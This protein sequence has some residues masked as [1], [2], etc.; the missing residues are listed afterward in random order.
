MPVTIAAI[1]L[2]SR[3][4]TDR[5]YRLSTSRYREND[6]MFRDRAIPGS[7]PRYSNHPRQV[8]FPNDAEDI[9]A[10]PFFRGIPWSRLHLSQPPFAPH[11]RGDQPITKYFD[12][13]EEIMSQSD[14]LDTSTYEKAPA[15][16]D[17][18]G[19][20]P[21]PVDRTAPSSAPALGTAEP[22]QNS[23]V[24]TPYGAFRDSMRKVRR[25]KDKKR[26]RDKLLRDPQ[27]G[28][29]VLEIRKKGA[30]IGYTYRRPTFSLADL[31]DNLTSGRAQ[32]AKPSVV[33]AVA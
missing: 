1:D 2:M 6:W 29:T 5:Q 28:R 25:R 4:L 22:K 30:F 31:E 13:E 7:R 11:L 17:P 3:L 18:N 15:M 10:H 24:S 16:D 8:V 27:F 19:A 26:P 14:H 12:D 9:K 32:T 20:V 33:A 21:T 23:P